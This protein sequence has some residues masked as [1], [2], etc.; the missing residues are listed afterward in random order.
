VLGLPTDAVREVCGQVVSEGGALWVANVNSPSQTVLSGS[1]VSLSQAAG[2]C[3]QRGAIRIRPL[4]VAY[5][6]HSPVMAGARAEVRAALDAA[7]IERPSAPLYSAVT[8]ECTREP[9]R[10]RQLLDA[11]M[12]EPVCFSAAVLAAAADGHREFLELGPGSPPRLLGLIRETLGTDGVRLALVSSDTEAAEPKPFKAAGTDP[13][14][15]MTEVG[16][17]T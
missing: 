6:A 15:A 17:G 8:G 1:L 10:I 12:T 16:H 2:L 3:L 13:A 5:A 11:G 4:R 7:T 14:A 9:R